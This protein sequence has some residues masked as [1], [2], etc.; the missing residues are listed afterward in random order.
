MLPWPSTRVMW[1]TSILTLGFAIAGRLHLH[2]L[3]GQ[4][5]RELGQGLFRAEVVLGENLLE[6]GDVRIGDEAPA[7]L[8]AVA[9]G[10]ADRIA[11][12]ADNRAQA[13]AAA[14]VDADV[15]L[16]LALDAQRVVGDLRRPSLQERLH[17]PDELVPV[18]G[19]AGDEGVNGNDGLDG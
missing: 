7:S 1:W 6:G 17:R 12:G 16:E 11:S 10:G 4:E 9:V 19:A 2:G 3:V 18:D 5:K 13:G 8:A 14:Q 15:L